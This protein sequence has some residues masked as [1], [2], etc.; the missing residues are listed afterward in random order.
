[1]PW[2]ARSTLNWLVPA[3]PR[4]VL[5]ALRRDLKWTITAGSR[6]SGPDRWHLDGLRHRPGPPAE[7]CEPCSISS[8]HGHLQAR[9]Q[10]LARNRRDATVRAAGVVDGGEGV[11]ECLQ[12]TDGGGLVRLG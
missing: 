9:D 2:R 1:M 7:R 5:T 12:V 4:Q 3:A 6:Q 10:P 11:Q 8:A